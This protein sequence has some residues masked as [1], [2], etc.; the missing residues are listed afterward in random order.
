MKAVVAPGERRD[1][2]PEEVPPGWTREGQ[3]ITRTY[4]FPS[5]RD[6]VFFVNAVA[7]LA[8]AA[9]HHPDIQLSWRRVTLTLTTHSAGGLTDRD[10]A[11]AEAIDR[12]TQRWR[13]GAP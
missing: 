1:P 10:L 2:Q 8:E 7:A 4:Q 3:A 9:N 6:A 11:L 12:H 13:G 5:F